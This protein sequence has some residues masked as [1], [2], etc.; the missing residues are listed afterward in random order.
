MDSTKLADIVSTLFEW[1]ADQERTR[2][3]FEAKKIELQTLKREFDALREQ[4]SLLKEENE[5]FK[6][7]IDTFKEDFD[8]ERS[9]RENLAS[10]LDDY[11]RMMMAGQELS[12]DIDNDLLLGGTSGTANY[13]ST[14]LLVP[15][16]VC[17]GSE[18]LACPKCNKSYSNYDHMELL[19]HMTTCV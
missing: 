10:Q 15:R 8:I 3:Q 6:F 19:D 9:Q 18:P 13:D 7:Q 1:K 12:M 17:D 2:R 16:T 14:A 11:K 4:N 5:Q